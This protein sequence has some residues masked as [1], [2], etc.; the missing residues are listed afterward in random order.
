MKNPLELDRNALTTVTGGVFVSVRT[1]GPGGGGGFG[2][3]AQAQAAGPQG[4]QGPQAAAAAGAVP[5][6]GSH[7]RHG[8]AHVSISIHQG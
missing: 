2:G 6:M 5:Q 7:H 4:P 8:G 1:G 3:A